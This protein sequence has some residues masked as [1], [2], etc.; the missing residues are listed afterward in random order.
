MKGGRSIFSKLASW[1]FMK[2]LLTG[3]TL[4]IFS[5]LLLKN[6]FWRPAGSVSGTGINVIPSSPHLGALL[7][8][9]Y[10]LPR[11]PPAQPV[12]PC[13]HWAELP[14]PPALGFLQQPTLRHVY[15]RNTGLCASVG[16]TMLCDRSSLREEWLKTQEK[17]LCLLPNL[18]ID[19]W[20][21]YDYHIV[22]FCFIPLC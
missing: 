11:L 3:P 18:Y 14:L 15:R 20:G 13:S 6:T 10:L 12:A 7:E 19:N 4:R 17:S 16:K 5:S 22:I 9:P 1:H 8:Q 21:F 2:S